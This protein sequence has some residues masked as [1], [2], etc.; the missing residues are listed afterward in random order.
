MLG[1]GTFADK[2]FFITGAGTGIGRRFATHAAELGATVALGGRRENLLQETADEIR[3][4]GGKVLICPVDIRK[5]DEVEATIDNIVR[6]TGHIDVLINNAAGNFISR[7]EEI[8]ANGWNAVINIVLNGTAYCTLA[9]GRHMLAQGSG[10]VLSISAAYAWYGGPGTAHSAAAKA[11]VIAMSQ[12]LAVEWGPRNVQ[13]NCL[14]PGFVDTE[15][16]RTALWPTPDGQQR[17]LDS[18]PAGRFGTI[19]ET[20][21]AGLFMCCP[22]SGYINGEVLVIDGGQWLNK[23]VFVLPQPG[24]RYQKV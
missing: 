11:G 23:G 8:S 24:Q 6:E 21:E 10:K 5:P 13:V 17:I 3:K 20:V 15:Q 18:I 16:S 14:C 9:A 19:D 22:A 2:T 12:T 7:A 1:A 4:A